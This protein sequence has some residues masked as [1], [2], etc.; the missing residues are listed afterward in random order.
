MKI[1]KSEIPARIDVPGATARQA[2]DFGNA[3]GYGTMAGEY[4]SLKKG[5]DIA[6]LLKGLESD[7]CQSPHWGYMIEGRLRV[8]YAGGTEEMV[9]GGDLFYWPPGHSVRADADA[10]FIMFSPQAE[11][12]AVVEHLRKQLVP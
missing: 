8:T 12:C 11:H 4:F 1:A 9:E 7:L 10:E 6:P 5:T 2:L 3:A